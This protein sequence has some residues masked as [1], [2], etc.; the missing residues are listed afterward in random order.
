MVR[1]TSLSNEIVPEHNA[2]SDRNLT[3]LAL[4]RAPKLELIAP[5]IFSRIRPSR[6]GC[7]CREPEDHQENI[8]N[9]EGIWVYESFCPIEDRDSGEIDKTRDSEPALLQQLVSA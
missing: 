5:V 4:S 7:K 8:D 3:E 2:Q 9:R 6:Y 1:D